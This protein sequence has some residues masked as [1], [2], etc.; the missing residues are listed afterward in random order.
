M[1]KNVC[2]I[3]PFPPPMTGNAKAVETIVN[4]EKCS[5]KFNFYK[6]NLSSKG[7]RKSGDISIEKI[8]MIYNSIKLLRKVQSETEVDTYYLTIAQSMTGC[9]RDIVLL[10]TIYKKKGNSKV[11]LHLHGGGFKEFINNTNPYIKYL[12]KKYYSKAD[13]F[14]VLSDSLKVMFNGFAEENSVKVVENCVDDEF[15]I[16][17]N[18]MYKKIKSI[19]ST[20]T[21][22]VV[23]LSNMIKTKGY[24]DV[25]ES[26]KLLHEKNINC[27]IRFAGKFSNERDKEE[28]YEFI[29]INNLE[30]YVEYLGV[31]SGEKK[32]KL[33]LESH[34]FL[35]PT[36]FP[37]E[38]QP[39]S[40]L[41]A[42]SAGMAIIT[43]RQGGI[44]DVITENEN[45]LF[46][47]AQDI[48]GITL[49]ILKLVSTPE[50]IVRFGENNRKKV[51]ERY[52]ESHYIENM[53]KLLN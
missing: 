9:I 33:L 51:I 28:F 30:D 6:I 4:S 8:K 17:N 2:M 23:Y 29:K 14:I 1:K 47:K 48:Q 50:K 53:I 46:V 25:L 19:D 3:A 41:E 16:S 24:F 39:I 12:I 37:P 26:A 43:T 34:V 20:F 40:I 10:N 32:R 7:V 22:Q 42:M 52:L 35:L 44:P 31:V 36:Y 5:E 13:E 27:K 15:L 21:L 49:A 38:G 18:E 45:G 11:V